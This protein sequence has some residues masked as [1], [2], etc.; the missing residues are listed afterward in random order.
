MVLKE[1]VTGRLERWLSQERACHSS[2]ELPRTTYK[3]GEMAC[4]SNSGMEGLETGRALRLSDHPTQPCL[5]A[6]GLVES[7]LEKTNKGN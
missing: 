2:T 3:P 6:P 1:Y 4:I 7:L 5:W